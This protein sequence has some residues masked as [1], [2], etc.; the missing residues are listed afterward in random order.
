MPIFAKIDFRGLQY[1][2]E[3]LV[4]L[5][6]RTS[7]CWTHVHTILNHKDLTGLTGGSG[8]VKLWPKIA[9]YCPLLLRILDGAYVIMMYIIQLCKFNN[10]DALTLK[11]Y[12]LFICQLNVISC[13]WCKYLLQSLFETQLIMKVIFLASLISF[14]F[15]LSVF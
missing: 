5:K 15:S 7:L 9:P 6:T 10:L 11:S 12:H 3:V 2:P 1:H 4:E 14:I 8:K 13:S